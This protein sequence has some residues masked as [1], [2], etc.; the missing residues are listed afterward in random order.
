MKKS[1]FH[2]N[3]E[4]ALSHF[5]GHELSYEEL[6]NLKFRLNPIEEIKGKT[7]SKDSWMK[8]VVLR[9]QN[10]T[11]NFQETLKALSAGNSH[12]PLWVKAFKSR[13]DLFIL[14][15]STRF[16][17]I[18][19]CRNQELGFPPFEL[20]EDDEPIS[21]VLKKFSELGYFKYC[22]P[23]DL[24][25][26]MNCLKENIE[27]YG[28][29]YSSYRE[30]INL[31][32]VPKCY[33]IYRCDQEDLSEKG[34]MEWFLT[35]FNYTFKKLNIDLKWRDINDEYDEFSDTWFWKITLNDK[36]YKLLN[37]GIDSWHV[38]AKEFFM[39]IN[40]QLELNKVQERAYIISKGN[41]GMVAFITQE[42]SNFISKEIKIK[43]S[44]LPML[45]EE[46]YFNLNTK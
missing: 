30:D 9:N 23:D 39:M 3:F 18:K 34:G 16:R 13:N 35:R 21:E 24:I 6:I 32:N 46:W 15:F 37:D 45:P 22:E 28:Q 1:K 41:D 11:L 20:I 7:S 12:Y 14:N 27:L 33:R 31:N 17:N 4:K 5:I 43:K 42:I 40:D 26:V 2:I 25:Q 36:E 10:D 19:N 44:F 8:M 38:F 29:L